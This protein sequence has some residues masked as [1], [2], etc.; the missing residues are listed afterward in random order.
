MKAVKS[1]LLFVCG[2]VLLFGTVPVAQGLV[3]GNN[4]DIHMDIPGVIAND[5]HV[6]GRLESGDWNGNWSDP[7]KLVFHVDDALTT[8]FAM[9]CTWVCSLTLPVTMSLSTW[10]AGGR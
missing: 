9:Y 6:E 10:S 1:K 5:F 3:V 4:I 8:S 7:P 2:I